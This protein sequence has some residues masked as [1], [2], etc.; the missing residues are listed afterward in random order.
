MKAAIT[1]VLL[2]ASVG[3]FAW[4]VRRRLAATRKLKGSYGRDRVGERVSRFVREVLLQEK[5]IVQRP[6]AGLLHALVFWGFLAFGLETLDHFA[7]AYGFT[8]L[9]RQNL[10]HTAFSHFV[11]FWA[12]LVLVG[13]LGLAWRRFVL[14]PRVLGK[15]SPGS[16]LVT[17]FITVLM[18]TYLFDYAG[19]RE[20]STLGQVNWWVHAVTILAF[21]VLI[22]NSKHLHLVLSP[23]TTFTKD[24]ELARI[25]PL[26]FENE[27]IGA[28]KL[29]DLH[30]HT[31]LGAFTCVECG[32]CFE[33]CP[34][35]STGKALDPKQLMLDLRDGLLEDPE[36][37][38]VGDVISSEVLWQCTTCGACTYQ[39][40]VG[41]DQVIPIIEMRRGQVAGGAFPATMNKFFKDM[42]VRGNPWGHARHKADDF[43]AE[44]GLPAFDGSQ[45]VLYWMGC[46]ARFDDDYRKV[47]LDLAK[48]LRH[49]GVSFG[50]LAKES[51]TGD[52]VRR[53]GNEFVFADLAE[54][55]VAML[56]DASPKTILTTCPHCLRTL[57]E[58]RDF[59]LDPSVAVV[60]HTTFLESLVAAGKL[61]APQRD[62]ATVVYHDPCYLSRYEG[63]EGVRKPRDLMRGAGIAFVEPAK[64]GDK[65]FCCGAG[66]AML[67]TEETAGKRINHERT[68][69]LLE[70]G[71]TTIA[72]SCP[73]CPIMLR[74]G[75]TARERKDVVVKDV[76]QLL[77]AGI[78]D[79]PPRDGSES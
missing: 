75:L 28:E 71:S 16:A 6:V 24:F 64:T 30:I 9:G 76:A 23:F 65:S 63:D 70:T 8:I 78:P 72:T 44:S 73:F 26:D 39:C 15:L 67:F 50:V 32:R 36:Q 46:L 66:G 51:C 25:R 68:D 33:H 58:Y 31:G 62:G 43:L 14:K 55:N 35:S 41:I 19:L 42:E 69:Q 1:S 37:E 20:G 29:S 79:S 22:P 5:V 74:D 21:L 38:A 18:V 77:A 40:P 52:A 61:P 11:A 48:L 4:E 54:K 7:K 2:L 12:V 57:S 47:A 34:A 59:G 53:A 27:E 13:I 45:D 3:Y 17:A 56:N 49:A 10:F 60:H